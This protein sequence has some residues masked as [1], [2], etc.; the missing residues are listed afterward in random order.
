MYKNI[1]MIFVLLMPVFSHSLSKDSLSKKVALIV[2]N[3]NPVTYEIQAIKRE[4]ARDNFVIENIEEDYDLSTLKAN[5][6]SADV[7]FIMKIHVYNTLTSEPLLKLKVE[8][9]RLSDTKMVS[10]DFSISRTSTT[11]LAA[12]IKG[13]F[14]E[15]EPRVVFDNPKITSVNGNEFSFE[16]DEY[17]AVKR[18]D[19]IKIR[20][21]DSRQGRIDS[22]AIVHKI[23]DNTIYAKDTSKKVV[24]GDEVFRYAP[25]RS[26]FYINVGATLP[27]ERTLTAELDGSSWKSDTFWSVGFKIEGEY[28]RFL[29]YQLVSTT[30]FGANVDSGIN[31]YAMTG[32]GYRG[33]I[34]TWEIVP[35]FRVGGIYRALSLSPT[36]EGTGNLQ[37][38]SLGFGIDFGI[39]TVKRIDDMFVGFGVGFQYFP[40]SVTTVL[41]DSKKVKPQWLENGQLVERLTESIPY[42]SLKVGWFF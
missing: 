37:G 32:I 34:D 26:R 38:F 18:G 28:E 12:G 41:T 4:L 25:S 13:L 24:V 23:S 11:L 16:S 29:P 31:V 22:I 14:E 9:L 10:K 30:S 17:F 1:V 20:Y 3:V 15:L 33:I 42:L 5:P 40:F 35:Y 27:R 7:K 36:T 19:E 21:K 39:N 8:V 2:S 6:L